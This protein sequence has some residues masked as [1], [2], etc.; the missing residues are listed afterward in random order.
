MKDYILLYGDKKKEDI[1]CIK[2]MFQKNAKINLGWTEIDYKKNSRLIN[3]YIRKGVK[4]FVFLGL[5]VGWENLIKYIKKRDKDII[6]KVICNTQESL[7][8]YDYERENFFKLLS[9][10]KKNMINEIA[11]LRK[12]Q[13]EVYKKLGYKCSYLMPNYIL[14]DKNKREAK[15]KNEK[16][17]IGIYPLNYTWDKNIF[18]QLCIAK[19]IENSNVNYNKLDE[20]MTEFLNTMNIKCS[21]DKIGK[22][23]EENII[24]KIVKND[25]NISCSFTE[26]FNTIFL[27]SMEQG[28]PCLVGNTTDFFEENNELKKYVVTL[29]EDDC[30]INSNMVRTCLENKDKIM[31]LYKKW[32]ERYNELA[33]RNKQVFLGM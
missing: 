30:I 17:D 33:E 8:Y 15:K 27:L 20:R 22:I 7:L 1:I 9:L 21:E 24:K 13:Y 23:N 12:G 16:I 10:S 14:E 26:Y 2:N 11:F 5:E 4:L 31:D 25:I 29:A 18:N 19:F 6:I 28:I 32:K 3:T